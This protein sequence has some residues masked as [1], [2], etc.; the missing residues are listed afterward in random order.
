MLDVTPW[1]M[2]GNERTSGSYVDPGPCV[3]TVFLYPY[4][5]CVVEHKLPF[6]CMRTMCQCSCDANTPWSRAW[7][8]NARVM[9]AVAA[10]GVARTA[11]DTLQFRRRGERAFVHGQLTLARGSV[12]M[13]MA[14]TVLI[15][16]GLQA[17]CNF[18]VV[19][20]CFPPHY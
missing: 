12:K 14:S 18:M 11:E 2:K 17:D 9:S 15:A 20:L 4:P 3:A 13:G 16:K 1:V 7:Q 5:K 19:G 6:L 8:M 10:P